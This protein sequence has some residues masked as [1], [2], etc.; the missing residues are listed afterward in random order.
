MKQSVF[1]KMNKAKWQ[2]FEDKLK[3]E[4]TPAEEIAKMYVHLTE[5]LAF[6][7]GRYPKAELTAYLNKLALKAHNLVYQNKPERK[8]RIIT[9][10]RDEVPHLMYFSGRQMLYSFLL[11]A[12]GVLVGVMS[13][14]HDET[15]ARL[16]LGDD[17]V[18]M[19]IRNI[20]SGKPMGVYG[21]MDQIG[22]FFYI[23]TN[24]IR[25]SFLAFMAGI[26]S[27]FFVGMIL[28]RNGVML[29]VFHYFFYQHG[30]FDHNILTIWLHGTIEITSIVLAGSAG[31]IL[32]NG[33][34]FPGTYPRLESLKREGKRGLKIVV[35]L[36]PFFII[37]GFIESFITRY[38]D[39]PL[40]LKLAIILGSAFLMLYYFV[41]LPTK[42]KDYAGAAED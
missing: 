26:L 4:R 28:F 19:T 2:E 34:L 17:Y 21:S 24:N 39:M 12:A 16:I 1:I 36:I 6:S 9:F 25:V 42:K 10:W 23:T 11:L 31:L 30:I 33:L 29:G 32:G 7:K 3:Q 37:A 20:E 38:G 13:G 18:D 5:D 8:S 35:G 15:F 22:M 41:F 14:V 40:V 27:S